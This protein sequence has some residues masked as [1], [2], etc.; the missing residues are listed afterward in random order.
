MQ[1][2][3]HHLEEVE[4]EPRILRELLVNYEFDNFRHQLDE[5]LVSGRM[6]WG[7]FG[8]LDK[9]QA[10]QIAE[11]AIQ[12]FK[13][14]PLSKDKLSG[15]RMVQAPVGETRLDFE[16]MDATNDNSCYFTHFMIG[17]VGA[18]DYKGAL[19]ATMFNQYL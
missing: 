5:W 7:I 11:N 6:I 8:N 18:E 17:Q 15:Y 13:L 10:I 16:L 9:E 4:F 2:S 1:L 14:A 19:M 12:A 3:P